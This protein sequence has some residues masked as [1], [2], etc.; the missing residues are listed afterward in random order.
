MLHLCGRQLPWMPSSAPAAMPV[1]GTPVLSAREV[2]E[3][4]QPKNFPLKDIIA[5]VVS[6][7]VGES[8]LGELGGLRLR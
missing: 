2:T 6:S 7:G 4:L 1:P 3:V 5:A 8:G